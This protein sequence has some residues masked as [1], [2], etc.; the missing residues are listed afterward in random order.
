M[1]RLIAI[2]L[3]GAAASPALAQHAGHGQATQAQNPHAAHAMPAPTAPEPVA[4]PACTPEH[5]AMGHCTMPA[6]PTSPPA[7]DPHAGHAAPPSAPA[8]APA[9]TPSPACTPEH[10]AMGHCTMTVRPAPQPSPTP[11][12]DPHDG[13]QM[14]PPPQA[15]DSHAGHQMPSQG[16]AVADPH[17]GHDMAGAQTAAPPQGPPPPEALAGP[18]HAADLVFSPAEMGQARAELVEGHGGAESYKL[19]VDQLEVSIGEGRESYS[20]DAQFWYGGDIDKFWLKTEGEGE[21]GGEFEG[22][23]IQGL[24]SRAID[25]WFDLQAGVRQDLRSGPDRTHLVLGVQGLAPYW[26]EV[27]GAVFLSTEGEVTARFE[28]EYDL[29]LTQQLILQP[30]IEA[31]F[32]LQDVPELRLGSGLTTAEI[33]AR[34]RYELYPRS[35]PAVIAPYLGVQYERAFGDTA[36]F[37]RAA[38]ED[39]GGWRLLLGLRTWF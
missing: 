19:L 22:V 20:W 25:P 34:L 28:G 11:E 4:A 37:R 17:A 31:D 14:A 38:G 26:F 30:L 13:H 24:W 36:D 2:L 23:E 9:P 27:E 39:V 6:E 10:A 18:A 29:R 1:K 5:A 32:S 12:A 21:F 3:A 16:E 15:T 7:T 8:P 33:G 35:G